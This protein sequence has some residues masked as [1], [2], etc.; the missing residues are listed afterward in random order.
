MFN[1]ISAFL[2]LFSTSV[3]PEPVC[4]STYISFLLFILTFPD[5]A[6]M[7]EFSVMFNVLISMFPDVDF[8][9][10]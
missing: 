5:L 6:S 4:V 9:L 7:L 3:F 10:Q 8:K 2:L 1:T